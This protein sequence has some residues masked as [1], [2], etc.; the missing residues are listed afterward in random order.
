MYG[1]YGDFPISVRRLR[2][3]I[4]NGEGYIEMEALFV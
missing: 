2:D 3:Q 1:V 4:E